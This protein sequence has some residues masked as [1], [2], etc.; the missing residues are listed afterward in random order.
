[1]G[2]QGLSRRRALELLLGLTVAGCDECGT[3]RP[4]APATTASVGAQSERRKA[5]VL[6]IGAGMAG[7]AAASRLRKE[8]A[9]VIVL[10]AR[11]RAG[12]R[13]WTNRSLGIPFDLGASWIH[14]R[15]RNPLT[16]LASDLRVKTVATD[17][18]SVRLFDHDGSIVPAREVEEMLMAWQ[19][20]KGEIS[21]Q[22][23][24]L[25]HDISVGAAVKRG[26]AGEELTDREQRLATWVLATEV[27]AAGEDLERLSLS[28]DGTRGFGG[29]DLI[30]P[31]GYDQLVRAVGK[32]VDVRFKHVVKRIAHR[33]DGVTVATDAGTFEAGRA[34]VTVPLGVLKRGAIAFVPGLDAA[35]LGAVRKLGMGT[36][37]KVAMVFEETFWPTDRDF[38]GYASK[39]PGHYPVFLNAARFAKRPA[40][41]AFVGGTQARSV[42]KKTDATI[43]AEVMTVLRTMF[44]AK[45]SAPK[46]L[47]VTRWSSD[48]WSY[49]SYS[50]VP[51]GATS[52]LYDALAEPMGRL[53]FAGEATH[54]DHASTVH[55]ALLSGWREADAVI[56]EAG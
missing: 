7:L 39:I 50:H 8:G 45:A 55:G 19:E 54:S 1:M 56:A 18:G 31:A 46:K 2:D 37:D 47:V 12:G 24:Q 36:L 13:V 29:G 10:E 41:M 25:G 16:D 48:R 42:E 52:R 21:S 51:V 30:I 27:T 33:G 14:G 3:R 28:G 22:A 5:D 17:Y 35:K 11:E 44:G 49:G 34:I 40:L 23:E 15:R 4:P 43:E 38:L 32:D 53:R 9:Q 26:L 6:V 20:L